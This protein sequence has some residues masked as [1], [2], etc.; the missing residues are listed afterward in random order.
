MDIGKEILS[1]DP[2]YYRPA[3]VDYLIGDAS[4]AKNKLGWTP[5]YDLQKLIQ[6]MVLSDIELLKND[7]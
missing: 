7:K 1:I 4:K 3:E 2:D 5:E 6:E